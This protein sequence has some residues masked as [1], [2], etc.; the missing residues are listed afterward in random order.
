MIVFTKNSNLKDF[1]WGG[2]GEGGE[3][4]GEGGGIWISFKHFGS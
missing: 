3:G 2:G 1:F 4:T